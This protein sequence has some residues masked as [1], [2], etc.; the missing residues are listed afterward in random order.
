[1]NAS[2]FALFGVRL[3]KTSDACPDAQRVLHGVPDDSN[4]IH[5]QKHIQLCQWHLLDHVHTNTRRL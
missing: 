2:D 4:K 3:R 1:M 5:R